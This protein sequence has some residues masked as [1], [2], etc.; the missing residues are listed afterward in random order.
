MYYLLKK[1]S[2]FIHLGRHDQVPIVVCGDFNSLPDSSV[3][4]LIY[5]EKDFTHNKYYNDDVAKWYE[6]VW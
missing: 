1:L 5:N 4:S 6:R 2:E 3:F